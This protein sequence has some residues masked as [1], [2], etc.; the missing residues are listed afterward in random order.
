VDSPVYAIVAS[1]STVYVGGYFATAGSISANSIAKWDGSTWSPLGNGITGGDFFSRPTVTAIAVSGS[2]V[3]AGGRFTRAGDVGANNIAKW[4]VSTNVWSALDKGI[5]GGTPFTA[6]LAIGVSGSIV[7]VGGNFTAAGSTSVSHIAKWD[8]NSWSALGGGVGGFSFATAVYAIA[9]NGDSVYVGGSFITAG[10]TSA[11]S[12]AKWDVSMSSWSAL[13]SGVVQSGS[14]S[15]YAIAA[16]DTSVYVGGYFNIA[17]NQPASHI[18]RW[19]GSGWSALSAG[20][21]NGVSGTIRAIATSGNIVYVGGTFATVGNVAANNIARWN[22][23]TNNW[24]ALGSGVDG[25]VYAI[26]VSGNDVY[27]GGGFATA[28][29]VNANNVAK[30]NGNNWA[31]LGDGVGSEVY[32]I[33]VSG[34]DVYAG[35]SFAVAGNASASHIARWDGNVWSAL[36]SGLGG[37][38]GTKYYYPAVYAISISGADVLVGGHFG[39]AGDVGA[40]HIAK[41]SR[42][43]WSRLGTGVDDL[44]GY[45]AAIA[46]SGSDVYIGGGFY[47]VSGVSARNIAKW[48]GSGWS[49]L[50]SGVDSGVNAIVADRN[51]AY[52][53]GYFSTAG[54]ASV[55]NIAQ[56]NGCG[57]Q[58]LGSGVDN[59]VYALARSG[60][61]VYVGGS[62]TTAGGKPSSYFA[63]WTKPAVA[64]TCRYFYFPFIS[65]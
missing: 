13:S 64:T 46:V 25:T 61:D 63:R 55:S 50:G 21:N 14:A 59:R 5:G 7:Y 24:S 10:N 15:V 32:A 11:S 52:T 16:N 65:K 19:N 38:I 3:Y 23:S 62:F 29:G 26:A 54:G 18:A 6:V 1:G 41:W 58:A 33:A 9:V 47:S 20:A 39:V 22:V 56:W 8:G 49:A 45:V 53:G 60:D 42:Q 28:G 2:D 17:G 31:S 4:N 37:G 34:T 36:G 51:N 48:N 12:I 57:W 44:Y 40:N 27:V 43:S 30:W 35:G